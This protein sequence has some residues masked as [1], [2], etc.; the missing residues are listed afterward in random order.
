MRLDAVRAAAAEV[1]LFVSPSEWLRRIFVDSGVVEPARIVVSENGQDVAAFRGAP[2][3]RASAESLRVGFMGALVPDKGVHVLVEAMNRLESEA[4]IVAS[5][6][7]AFDSDP[8]YAKRLVDAVRNPR[9]SFAGGYE[10]WAAPE[11]LASLDVL[12]VPSLW[13]E[14]SPLTIQEAFLAGVPPVVAA[15]GGMAEKV[16]DGVNGIHVP[17]GDPAALADAILRL[18]RDRALLARLAASR[19]AVKDIQED[20]RQLET[21]Y[22]ALVQRHA[23]TLRS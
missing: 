11:V 13:W 19:P 20:A 14:N 5:I 12:V 8:A 17:P 3:A 1:D 10:P 16:E 22:R 7:G 15:I 9:L 2:R 23:A 6:H 4:G 21:R 18:H